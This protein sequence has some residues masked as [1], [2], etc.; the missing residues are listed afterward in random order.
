[1]LPLW[2]IRI[3]NISSKSFFQDVSEK[4]ILNSLRIHSNF[5]AFVLNIKLAFSVLFRVFVKVFGSVSRHLTISLLL[6]CRL[7]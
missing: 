2:S 4:S 1:M 3:K 7:N 6:R 5:N